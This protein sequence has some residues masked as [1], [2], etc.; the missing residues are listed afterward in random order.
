MARITP[1]AREE[2]ARNALQCYKITPL[3][4][5]GIACG[6]GVYRRFAGATYSGA[7]SDA[8]NHKWEFLTNSAI[9]FCRQYP[10][11]LLSR[12]SISFMRWS[13]FGPIQ[14]VLSERHKRAE[15]ARQEAEASRV[16]VQEK[17]RTYNRSPTAQG[18][19]G[20]LYRAGNGSPASFGGAPDRHR[21]RADR[22]AA[23]FAGG[24]ETACG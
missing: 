19:R 1:A 9:C 20:S 13:F 3:S 16:V 5:L 15:G 21:R 17:L 4:R 14:R 2:L 18:A 24:Q 11:S 7:L 8:L 6:E 12:S 22:C 10:R 23:G